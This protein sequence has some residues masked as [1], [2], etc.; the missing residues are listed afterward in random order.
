MM[1]K[2]RGKKNKQR[3]LFLAEISAQID[4]SET[5]TFRSEWLESSLNELER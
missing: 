4:A 2:A 3:S 1:L 5:A